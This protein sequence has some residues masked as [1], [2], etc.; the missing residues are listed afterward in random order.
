ML[1]SKGVINIARNGLSPQKELFAIKDT[2]INTL[3]QA[4]DGKDAF[5]FQ[6]S[7]ALKEKYEIDS[8]TAVKPENYK[9]SPR[10][11]NEFTG[12]QSGA[13][14]A[15]AFVDGVLKNARILDGRTKGPSRRT[16]EQDMQFISQLRNLIVDT[17]AEE[18]N[19]KMDI[20]D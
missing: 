20:T 4:V 11:Y 9:T 1:Y 6:V 2:S 5:T 15:E 8:R 18:H 17:L 13:N 19:N 16:K 14:A 12:I 3:A 10:D 7:T